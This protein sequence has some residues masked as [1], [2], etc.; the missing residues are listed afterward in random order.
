M[1][2]GSTVKIKCQSKQALDDRIILSLMLSVVVPSDT[3]TAADKQAAVNKSSMRH[4]VKIK[5]VSELKSKLRN[6]SFE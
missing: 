5:W 6:E 2:A 4:V 1:S 3:L